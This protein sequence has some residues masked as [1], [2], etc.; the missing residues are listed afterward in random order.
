MVHDRVLEAAPL[1]QP[2]SFATQAGDA[3]SCWTQ[4]LMYAQAVL[5]EAHKL[6]RDLQKNLRLVPGDDES[7]AAQ[8]IIPLLSDARDSVLRVIGPTGLGKAIAHAALIDAAPERLPALL[9]PCSNGARL[10][11]QLTA[12]AGLSVTLVVCEAHVARMPPVDGERVS[13]RQADEDRACELGG[14]LS[15][16]TEC[17]LEL[18]R[19]ARRYLMGLQP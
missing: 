18:A 4:R 13:V 8:Q 12:E 16:E 6:L 1:A 7:I 5:L 17:A 11:Y 2:I 14:V 10:L 19:A 15:P 3:G 9:T